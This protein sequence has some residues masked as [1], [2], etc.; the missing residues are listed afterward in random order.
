MAGRA[1]S[2]RAVNSILPIVGGSW[3]RGIAQFK[4]QATILVH[5]KERLIS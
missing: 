2:L 1:N 4:E 5:Q 3:V